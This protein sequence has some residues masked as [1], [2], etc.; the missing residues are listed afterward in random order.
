MTTKFNRRQLAGLL[1]VAPLTASAQLPQP[2][3]I[4]DAAAVRDQIKSNSE[5]IRKFDL[6]TATEP[7]FIF[8]P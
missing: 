4:D 5:K 6:P 2:P 8:K 3:V 7:S 1:A